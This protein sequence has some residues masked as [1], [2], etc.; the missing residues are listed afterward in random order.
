VVLRLSISSVSLGAD[1]I[2]YSKIDF[3]TLPPPTLPY[4][5]WDNRYVLRCR[6]ARLPGAWYPK[7]VSLWVLLLCTLLMSPSNATLMRVC[8]Q[9]TPTL[10]SPR[11]TLTYSWRTIRCSIMK[12]ISKKE[13]SIVITVVAYMCRIVCNVLSQSRA[14]LG[15]DYFDPFLSPQR[16]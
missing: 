10:L 8:K 1:R 2:K 7:D 3:L 12:L 5:I 6:V 16:N 11:L 14:P 4:I 13:E 15:A 9:M